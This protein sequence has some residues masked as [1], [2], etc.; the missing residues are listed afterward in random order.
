VILIGNGKLITRNE[1]QPFYEDG[2]VAVDNNKIVE[3]GETV[4]L[5]IKYTEAEFIDA[6]GGVIMPGLINMHQHIYSALARG[7]QMKNSPINTNFNEILENLWW[8]LDRGLGLEEIK[9]SAYTTYIEGIKN[10]V[11]TVFDHH[12][13]AGQIE[14]SLMTIA[15]AASVLGVRT[16]LCYEVTD[17]DGEA[18]TQAGIKENKDFIAYAGTAD[19]MLGGLFG[20]HA[21]FTVSDQ[22]LDACLS[23]GGDKS[24]FHV[25][26]A[27]GKT[28]VTD[29]LEKYK[30][31][32]VKRFEQAGVLGEKT[33][34]VHCIHISDSEMD[35]LADTKTA[36]IHNPQSNMGNAVGCADIL[37]QFQKGVLSGMGTDGYTTD[38]LM[39]MKT[40]N[41]LHKHQMGDPS[42]AWVEPP[43]ML[44]KNNATIVN[45]HIEGNIGMIEEGYYADI[46]VMDYNPLTPMNEANIDSHMHFGM[47]GSMVTM[48]MINGNIVYKDRK[49]TQIDEEEVFAKSRETAEAFWARV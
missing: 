15:D 3:Y 34:A 14:G 22:T 46:I 35:V 19:D 17:R 7:M 10:G 20:L 12:A 26:V 13:S 25:H 43:T 49:M 37:T 39:S 2:C 45:R 24:G 21:S 47:A 23:A 31:P 40:A 38:M 27:E 11:T 48:T 30:V 5:K 4:Y 36:V 29:S 1:K 28:D 32:V 44:F 16:N 8:R 41:I 6:K 33:L 18:K 9:Y 42:V